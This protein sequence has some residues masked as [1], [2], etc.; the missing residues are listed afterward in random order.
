MP[1]KA[2]KEA[3]QATT[4]QAAPLQSHGGFLSL[5]E[6]E[7]L[8]YEYQPKSLDWYWA[9]GIIAFGFLFT[10]ILLKNF[11]FA[12]LVV[13]SAFSLAMYGARRPKTLRAAIT[14]RGVQAGET[15]Y[16][17]DH[18]SHFWVNYDPPHVRELYLVSKKMFVPYISIPL[19]SADPNEIREHLLKFME[20]KQIGEPMYDVIARLLRF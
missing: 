18:L 1:I 3:P 14:P 13:L 19:G 5:I 6:W 9:V 11:L 8:E 16:P 12:I 10:A 15:L 7:A 20:E 2:K 17:Y 4:E